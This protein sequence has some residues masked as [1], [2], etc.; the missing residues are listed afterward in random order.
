MDKQ[1]QE[2]FVEAVEACR[3][4]HEVDSRIPKSPDMA[5]DDVI[6][7]A[8]RKQEA[9]GKGHDAWEI[10]LRL[11]NEVFAAWEKIVDPDAAVLKKRPNVKRLEENVKCIQE[12]VDLAVNVTTFLGIEQV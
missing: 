5:V 10:A 7:N 6:N 8:K 12:I 1:Y 11:A 4:A 3:Q 2:I 9:W